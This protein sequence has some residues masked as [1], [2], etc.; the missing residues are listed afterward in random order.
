MAFFGY[1]LINPDTRLE[2]PGCAFATIIIP[3]HGTQYAKG[4]SNH[5]FSQIKH[6]ASELEVIE[7]L[8]EPIKR[9]TDHND[10]LRFSYSKY[11]GC[12]NYHI[13]QVIFDEG[14]VI[15]KRAYYYMD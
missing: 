7:L 14:K 4:Y 10:V 12:E 13:R 6:G 5:G 3:K 2:S 1:W 15:S 8:G 11:V 9:W